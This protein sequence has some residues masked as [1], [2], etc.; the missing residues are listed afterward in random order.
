MKTTIL[1]ILLNED[2]SQ[3]KDDE[4]K[5]KMYSSEKET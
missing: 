4:D 3:K 5:K 1:K 2:V